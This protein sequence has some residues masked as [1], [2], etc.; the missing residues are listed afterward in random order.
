MNKLLAFSVTALVAAAAIGYF[1]I[2]QKQPEAPSLAFPKG[3]LEVFTK[4]RTYSLEIEIADTPE[5]LSRG[6][7]FRDHLPEQSG[8]LFIFNQLTSSGF[9]MF[10]TKIPLSIAFTDARGVILKILDMAPC[11]SKKPEEC[12]TYSPQVPYRMAL[13]VNQGWFKKNGVNEGDYISYQRK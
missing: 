10:N 3:S 13:E 4:A 9:W 1:L 8:M 2:G 6:L 5:R 7:M 12:P 11:Q